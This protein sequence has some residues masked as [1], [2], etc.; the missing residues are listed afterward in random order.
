M[1]SLFNPTVNKEMIE[2]IQK[3]N[4]NTKPAWGK[5]TV[6]QMVMHSQKPFQ[7]AYKELQ[8]KRGIIGILFGGIAKKKLT[9]PEP[10]G[11]NLP[12]D[13]N[14]KITVHPE[15]EREKNN[16]ISCVQRFSKNGPSGIAKEP[17]PFFG[18]LTTEEWDA[19]MYKHL[20][21]HLRQFGA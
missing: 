20:D 12:T 16:L 8:L 21:H 6:A 15:F 14:F 17:H 10:F 3:L 1:K 19:L 9:G 18:K 5:M 11:K 2:R 7:V 4:A 13:K